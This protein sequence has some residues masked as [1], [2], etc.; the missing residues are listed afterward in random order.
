MLLLS[1]LCSVVFF[2]VDAYAS[3]NKSSTKKDVDQSVSITEV[4]K[5]L[6]KNNIPSDKQKILLDKFNNGDPWDCYKKEN[7]DSI[8]KDFYEFK[9]EDMEQERYYRFEDRSFVKVATSKNPDSHRRVKRDSQTGSFGSDFLDWKIE[10]QVGLQEA[11]FYA[12]F[13]VARP[14][15][16]PSSIKK[17]FGTNVSGF[18]M[19]TS[20]AFEEVRKTEELG[21]SPAAVRMNWMTKIQIS[22]SW[23]LVGGQL[24]IGSVCELWL[25]VGHGTYKVATRY[26]GY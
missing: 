17:F 7:L 12:D 10:H 16:D 18:G 14:G 25:T 21:R 15:F 24:P 6:S 20:P 13:W 9:I 2:N 19:D 23:K 8:P 3:D 26:P 4:K 11:F 1:L 22:G 5:F